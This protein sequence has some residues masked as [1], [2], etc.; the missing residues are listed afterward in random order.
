MFTVNI[1]ILSY[2]VVGL[3]FAYCVA[4]YKQDN[5]L[6]SS[7]TEALMIVIT[8]PFLVTISIIREIKK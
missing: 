4:S 1:F 5:G 8:W 3:C 6:K 7:A 2:L